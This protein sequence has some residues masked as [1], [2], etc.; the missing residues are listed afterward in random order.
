MRN[1]LCVGLVLILFAGCKS[2]I[3]ADI[4]QPEKMQ[5]ILYDIHI[6]DGY[7][8]TLSSSQDSAKKIAAAYYKGIYNKFA[9]DSVLY[10]K[11]MT[12]YYDH[13]EVLNGMY[14]Q[15]NAALK[16]SKDSLD[17][18]ESKR[19]AKLSA[20]Q[21]KAKLAAQ[22]KLEEENT[23]KLKDSLTRVARESVQNTQ[24]PA[25][26]RKDSLAKARRVK[27]KFKTLPPE[28]VN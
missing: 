1:F 25:K 16:K 21:K 15:V 23:K 8:S 13:P 20:A 3:P 19:V 6:A 11:S 17:K 22:N 12:F 14:D 18:V 26:L 4:I 28:K 2:K 27:K 9:I 24:S 7:V 10:T 5:V